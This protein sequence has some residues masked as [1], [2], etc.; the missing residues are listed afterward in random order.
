LAPLK[1]SPPIEQAKAKL[2]VV[3]PAWEGDQVFSG[4]ICAVDDWIAGGGVDGI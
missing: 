3:C 1:S 4:R 2:R